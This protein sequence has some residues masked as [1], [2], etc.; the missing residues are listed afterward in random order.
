MRLRDIP[1]VLRMEAQ[2]L[3]T[4]RAFEKQTLDSLFARLA[5]GPKRYARAWDEAERIRRLSEA[6]VYRLPYLNMG[7]CLK[8]ALLRFIHLREKGFNVRFHMGVKPAPEGVTGHAWL[9]LNGEPLWEREEF[10]GAFQET[11]AYP[12]TD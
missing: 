3:T 4:T 5:V 1:T 8:L 6:A 12:P 10:V 2:L 9:T 11:Y 7:N